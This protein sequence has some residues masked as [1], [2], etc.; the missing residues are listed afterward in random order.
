MDSVVL[1]M[2]SHPA[3]QN[4][5]H[6]LNFPLAAPSANKFKQ[7]SPTTAEHV[8]EG[9][10]SKVEYILDGGPSTVGIESTIIDCRTN[11]LVLLRHGGIS[12]EEIEACVGPI[13]EQIKG[14]FKPLSTGSDGSALQYSKTFKLS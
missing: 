14:A 3:T 10:G 7:I 12:K 2:P 1:R 11:D 5:L 4:L 8:A 9:L 6:L 13:K